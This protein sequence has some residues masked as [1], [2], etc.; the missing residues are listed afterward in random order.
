MCCCVT[1]FGGTRI[2]QLFDHNNRGEHTGRVMHT[3][4]LTHFIWMVQSFSCHNSMTINKY[5]V[6]LARLSQPVLC[7]QLVNVKKE[8]HK[9]GGSFM[10]SRYPLKYLHFLSFSPY[11]TLHWTVSIDDWYTLTILEGCYTP[12]RVQRWRKIFVNIKKM[13]RF[14]IPLVTLPISSSRNVTVPR[15]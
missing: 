14:R 5:T 7:P 10:H 8:F 6:W 1:Y 15:F 4:C 3:W 9:P 2:H 12:L 11:S 13:R